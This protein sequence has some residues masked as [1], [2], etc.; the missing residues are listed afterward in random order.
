MEE[1]LVMVM[2]KGEKAQESKA[3]KRLQGRVT[4]IISKVGRV[5]ETLDA[6]RLSLKEELVPPE[7]KEAVQRHKSDFLLWF[8]AWFELPCFYT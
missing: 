2:E 7:D 1:A 3:A 6:E 4:K 8:L 5:L